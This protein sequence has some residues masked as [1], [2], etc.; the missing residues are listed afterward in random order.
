MAKQLKELITRDLQK[1]IT[2][3]GGFIAISFHGLDSART[4]DLRRSLRQAGGRVVVVPN[5]IA[6]RA[7][8]PGLGAEAANGKGVLLRQI[9]TGPTALVMGDRAGDSDIVLA[10]SKTILQWRKKNED[11]ISV[12]GGYFGGALLAAEEVQRLAA[13]P[14]RR[15]LYTQVA[16]LFQSPL[17]NVAS[18]TNQILARVVYALSAYKEKLEKSGAGS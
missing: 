13:M 6:R 11:K 16:G 2:L 8:A 1:K 14:D 18:V 3:D 12:K 7:L 15:T 10:L 5:R 4:F 9:F 17:R